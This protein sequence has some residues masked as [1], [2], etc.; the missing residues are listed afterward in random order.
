MGKYIRTDPGPKRSVERALQEAEEEHY[1]DCP[2]ADFW[3]RAAAIFLDIIFLFI[4]ITAVHRI[5]EVLNGAL[6]ARNAIDWLVLS[7]SVERAT[8]ALV[9][10]LWNL[11]CVTQFGGTPAK[12]I[13]GLRVIDR[14]SGQKL[15]FGQT[16]LREVIGKIIL[17]G[18]TFGIG[19]L[20]PLYRTDDLT[21][22]DIVARSTVKR[23][24]HAA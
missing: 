7:L 10:Y 20:L 13:L 19:F 2:P 23:V 9:F 1:L 21:L 4:I 6:V 22:H 16:L 15:S 5:F 14:E 18:L 12:I 8:Q 17:C 24:R 11:W 3:I